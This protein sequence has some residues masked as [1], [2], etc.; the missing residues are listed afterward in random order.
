M[1]RFISLFLIVQVFFLFTSC[2]SKVYD[3][4]YEG[5]CIAQSVALSYFD[6]KIYDF[7]I[8]NNKVT[9]DGEEL[10]IFSEVTLNSD[11]IN[12]NPLDIE[13]GYDKIIENIKEAKEGL[14][15][16][17][18]S[19]EIVGKERYYFIKYNNKLYF[20][21]GGFTDDY[22]YSIIRCYELIKK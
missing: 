22:G 6:T 1:K 10:G 16:E 20:M 8:V 15:F 11:Y 17:S 19:S 21:V 2:T 14:I 12:E 9:V 5:K 18:P 7:S 4:K 3:G 13:E